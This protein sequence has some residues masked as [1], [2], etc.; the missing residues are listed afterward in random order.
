MKLGPVM[1]NKKDE[2]KEAEK[3]AA[4]EELHKEIARVMP[5]MERAGIDKIT[6][7]IEIL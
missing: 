6:V 5:L 2:K 1:E 7:K 3:Q 4:L